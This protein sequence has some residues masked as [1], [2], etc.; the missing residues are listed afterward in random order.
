MLGA[1]CSSA[2]PRDVVP[3]S[4]DVR[5]VRDSTAYGSGGAYVHV[6]RR[7]HA[8]VG[9]IGA[10]HMSLAE[11]TRIANL[12]ADELESCAITKERDG[13]LAV[14]AASF[15]LVATTR[16]TA[17]S[18]LHLA[19]GGPV[20]ANAIECIL[21]PARTIQLPPSAPNADAAI[22]ALAIDATWNPI[23]IGKP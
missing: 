17:V 8:V 6:A 1:A 21:A 15:V 3:E 7:P 20:A 13:A 5:D 9:L 12:V 4:H 22:P 2:A 14:G 19:P 10:K 23:A 18:E 16:G 11:A